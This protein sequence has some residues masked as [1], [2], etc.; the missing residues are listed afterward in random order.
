MQPRLLD[1]KDAAA[2]VGISTKKLTQL[3]NDG[4]IDRRYVGNR[5]KYERESLDAWIDTLP[6]TLD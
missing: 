4:E 6:D 5:P 3:A 2:Y 1:A